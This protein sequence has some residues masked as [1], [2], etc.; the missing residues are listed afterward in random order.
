MG[1][2]GEGVGESPRPLVFC[3]AP[4]HHGAVTP[5]T[6]TAGRIVTAFPEPVGKHGSA[7]KSA[8]AI[9]QAAE[10]MEGLLSVRRILRPLFREEKA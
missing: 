3:S 7:A 2:V 9:A 1:Q 10:E 5:P 6:E 8:R 4:S